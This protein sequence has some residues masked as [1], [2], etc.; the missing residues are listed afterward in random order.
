MPRPPIYQPLQ[1]S[2]SEIRLIDISDAQ[3]Y[4]LIH[5]SLLDPPPYSAL[6]YVWGDPSV[7]EDIILEGVA[8]PVT[9]NLAAA[10]KHAK[11]H[12][13][14]HYHDRDPAT[15]RLWADAICINQDDIAERNNQVQHMAAIYSSAD[16]VIAWLGAST[17]VIELAFK[18]FE[19]IG[20]ETS[21]IS[22]D[23]LISLG[24]LEKHP[25][26]YEDDLDRSAPN[27]LKNERWVA[28]SE[29]FEN[30]YWH[31]VWI[32]QEGAL[33]GTILFCA[34]QLSL[35]YDKIAQ[36]WSQ[37]ELIRTAIR[38]GATKRPAFLQGSLWEHLSTDFDTWRTI[39]RIEAGKLRARL[40]AREQLNSIDE[41]SGW[42]LSLTGRSYQATD[43][44]DHIY[45]LLALT[46]V[47]VLPDYSP[48]NS[49]GAVYREYVKALLQNYTS[50][51]KDVMPQPLLFL[52]YAGIGIFDNT[53]GLPTWAPNFPEESQKGL[54]GF[55]I[56]GTADFGVFPDSALAPAVDRSLL[57]VD[58]VELDAIAKIEH[59][60][61][62]DTWFDGSMLAY[63]KDFVQRNPTYVTG[64]P[65]LQAILRV[66]RLDT[67]T[68]VD[69]ELVFYA[70][71]MLEFI[72]ATDKQNLETNLL[73]L[74]IKSGDSF[75][76]A[77]PQ[78]V[79]PEFEA[80]RKDWWENFW[81]QTE[82]S[83]TEFRTELRFAVISDLTW[84]RKRWRF[85][86]TANGYFGLAPI[87]SNPGDIV[88]VLNGCGTP[89]ILRVIDDR[90]V[91]VGCC[92]IL[93][94]MTGE[95]RTI[96]NAQQLQI[97]KIE[98]S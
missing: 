47:N 98:I 46:R 70:F 39:E 22:E 20:A 17:R 16:I 69:D 11:F 51:W 60:P 21:N 50:D 19:V 81:S 73:D 25:S 55:F 36:V 48:E 89:V 27:P 90:L 3:S 42:M 13:I 49:V 65:P 92:F 86:E 15:F 74:G 57:V 5:A 31:R 59:A 84:L 4:R 9:N 71:S 83:R 68:A 8:F 18:T 34:D 94:L 64:I 77:F 26:L 87:N 40:L 10:L 63:F 82:Q 41:A 91:F 52:Y 32:V 28:L 7:T 97:R 95:T 78:C 85:C 75:N 1:A 61:H 44:K 66:I 80:P 76:S 38:S 62:E 43:P 35:Q 96:M 33:A 53:L 12:C 2:K 72:L 56:D 37:V 23:S 58:G 67:T 79:F 6:S 88:C 14:H 24:W 29:L 45:G 93:G 54:T 30:Q